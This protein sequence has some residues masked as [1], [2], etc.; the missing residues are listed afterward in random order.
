MEDV[1]ENKKTPF[2]FVGLCYVEQPKSGPEL[3]IECNCCMPVLNIYCMCQLG[4]HCHSLC[5]CSLAHLL[6]FAYDYCEGFLVR[7]RRLESVI[8]WLNLTYD[9][10]FCSCFSRQYS[11]SGCQV[12]N[13]FIALIT[14]IDFINHT[15]IAFYTD[16]DSLP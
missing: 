4:F 15:L 9:V 10:I 7:F 12:I 1:Q 5:F 16:S 3:H 13:F 8:T 11:P 6:H 2:K 14:A